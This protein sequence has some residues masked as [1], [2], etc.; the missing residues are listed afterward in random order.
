MKNHVK[1]FKVICSLQADN[2]EKDI[3]ILFGKSSKDISVMTSLEPRFWLRHL[4]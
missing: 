4:G 1:K 3:E 2:M